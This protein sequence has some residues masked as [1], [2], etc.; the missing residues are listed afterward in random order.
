MNTPVNSKRPLV[1]DA[2]N[3]LAKAEELRA[4]ISGWVSCTQVPIGEVDGVVFY[5]SAFSRKE[6]VDELGFDGVLSNY[7]CITLCSDHPLD[8][9]ED[10]LYDTAKAAVLSSGRPTLAFVQRK[11]VIGYNRAARLI[12][13]MEQEGVVSRPGADGHRTVLNAAATQG[14]AA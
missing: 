13:R 7:E 5:L 1:L 12:E 9:M 2:V 11:L 4:D 3:L 6:A 10:E 8:A 14:G